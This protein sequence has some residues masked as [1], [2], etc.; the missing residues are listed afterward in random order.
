MK[1]VEVLCLLVL[2]CAIV[3]S[4]MAD[5]SDGETEIYMMVTPGAVNMDSKSGAVPLE[6]AVI[7]SELSSVLEQYDAETICCAAPDFD[8]SDLTRITPGGKTI[9]MLDLSRLYRVKFPEGTDINEVI[10]CLTGKNDI[11]YA[12]RAPDY[13]FFS[14]IPNDT[15]F[16][17]QW[18]L[19]NAGQ[20]GSADVDIDAP[21]AWD[22]EKGSVNVKIGILDT[23]VMDS[24]EDLAPIVSGEPGYYEE[25]GTH[26]AGIA[27]ALT[28]NNKGVAGVCWNSPIHS[29][30]LNLGNAG[31]IYEDICQ[32]VNA[33]TFVLN[34]SWGGEN[35][36]TT[37]RHA[38]A[39]AYKMNRVSVVS[40]GNEGSS[41]PQYPA[42]YGQGIVAVGAIKNTGSRPWWS[43]YGNHIDVVAPG[44]KNF[45]PHN[46]Y[47]DIYSTYT[48]GSSSY[49]YLAGTSMAAPFVTGVAALIKSYR[50]DLDNDDVMEIINLSGTDRDGSLKDDW[51]E[52]YGNGCVNANEALKFLRTP[53]S[54]A[55]MNTSSGIDKGHTD[56]YEITFLSVPGLADGTYLAERHRIEASVSYGSDPVY[57]M[58][59]HVWGRGVV[60]NGY[61]DENPNHAMGW[62]QP[63]EGTVTKTGC[64]LRTYVYEVWNVN[65]QHVGWYP[66]EPDQVQFAYTVL[67]RLEQGPPTVSLTNP[68]S[69]TYSSGE[70][71][72]VSWNVVDDYLP[73]VSCGILYDDKRYTGSTVVESGISV[74]ENGYGEYD[75]TVPYDYPDTAQAT[76]SVVVNDCSDYEATDESSILTF[77]YAS[78]P[79]KG[80]DEPPI[81]YTDDG[82]LYPPK[83]N[84]F[85]PAT[86][87]S[88][89]HAEPGRVS[90]GIYDVN[91]KLV[92]SIYSN[93][94]LGTGLHTT[95]WDGKSN[96]GL[97]VVSGIYFVNIRM[98]DCSQTRKLILL[99]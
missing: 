29:E 51:D 37:V 54:L 57:I 30:Q 45:F 5:E 25:H 94:H 67:G 39:Y 76:L 74:D 90:L 26:V 64:E 65:G 11:V 93:E 44:G 24:H 6:S 20:S 38:F 69:G 52:S 84:P 98:E 88:F 43:S 53:Y 23:G 62:T 2:V 99:R 1:S 70:I 91:G 22:Y 50:P 31:D 18:G 78:P 66:C 17:Y 47:E 41:T 49:R 86:E 56:K 59:P 83:P 75:F 7:S 82:E 92:K 32:A 71:I 77:Q 48:G 79:S 36:S 97:N 58:T 14:T 28:N 55:H 3:G 68:Q 10:G 27:A 15:Y 85:N 35:Y 8:N 61:T 95:V 89:Y 9:R 96:T 60:T 13:K 73:G 21:E 81:P 80:E 12:E 19:N 4:P 42:A 63:V 72:T 16:S 87:I 40:M 34:N 46:N 33:G